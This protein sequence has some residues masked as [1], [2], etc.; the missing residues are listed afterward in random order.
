MVVHY[1]AERL[2]TVALLHFSDGHLGWRANRF[3]LAGDGVI[4]TWQ[5]LA[6]AR[7]YRDYLRSWGLER[8]IFEMVPLLGFIKHS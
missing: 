5:S 1:N 7:H 8:Q 6:H 2:G 4:E 3:Y